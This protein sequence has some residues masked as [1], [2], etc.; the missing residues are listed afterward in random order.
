MNALRGSSKARVPAVAGGNFHRLL[1]LLAAVMFWVPAQSQGVPDRPM[2]IVVPWPAGGTGD[3]ITR[4]VAPR[5]AERIQ[6]PVVV[7]NKP[8]ANA[9]LGYDA[10]SKAQPD[11]HTLLLS[12]SV[13]YFVNPRLY[14]KLPYDT[15]N[16]FV[17]IALFG[18]STYVLAGR[19]GLPASSIKEL[20]A[21]AQASPG[22]LTYGSFGV[23]SMS[24]VGMEMIARKLGVKLFHVPY[25]G[26]PP[27][28][29]ALIAG[30]IDL[31]VLPAGLAPSLRDAGKIKVF[32]AL[33]E[34][35]LPKMQDLPTMKEQGYDLQ[36]AQVI[37]FL[38][39]AKTP[40][41]TIE[42]LNADINEVL[43]RPDV[44]SSLAAKNVDVLMGSQQEYASYLK[45]ELLRWGEV[46]LERTDLKLNK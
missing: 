1:V 12:S 46:V 37:G 30:Q 24:H 29:N 39:P 42:K 21:L 28:F 6:Q 36:L 44:R 2:K 22:K 5:L 8:G 17:P 3:V 27:S 43:K 7:E 41:A 10:V 23:G 19:T 38:A 31:L 34:K 15:L 32:G 20:V 35:R 18:T 40:P 33:S 11:G 4:V 26:G 14:T 45:T 9:I 25:N 16:D 13:E